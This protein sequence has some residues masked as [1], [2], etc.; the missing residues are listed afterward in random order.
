V[1]VR[2]GL[3]PG[4]IA[5]LYVRGVRPA[6]VR[7]WALSG[8]PWY[9]QLHEATRRPDCRLWNMRDADGVVIAIWGVAGDESPGVGRAF[10]IAAKDAKAH[11][12]A[13]H[14]HFKAEIAKLHALY[15]R[16]VA[17]THHANKLH[18]AWLRK[19]G[20]RFLGEGR[21]EPFWVRYHLYERSA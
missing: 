4:D 3:L 19:C 9:D 7:E 14:R 15:P 6:D 1:R 2:E 21:L 20:F 8:M 17:W 12:K 16:L 18:H 10:F 5:S 13:I 11:W